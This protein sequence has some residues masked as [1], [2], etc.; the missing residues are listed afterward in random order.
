MTEF[1]K[2]KIKT[3]PIK[4]GTS[5]TPQD[6]VAIKANQTTERASSLCIIKKSIHFAAQAHPA[7]TV[8]QDPF[9]RN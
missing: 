2:F 1:H 9:V 4:V 6:F 8:P 3:D 5:Q 7:G